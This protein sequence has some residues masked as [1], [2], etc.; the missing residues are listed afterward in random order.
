MVR[1]FRKWGIGVGR[2]KDGDRMQ[3]SQFFYFSSI[4]S[5]IDCYALL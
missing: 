1:A 2:E 5:N 4:S 3:K